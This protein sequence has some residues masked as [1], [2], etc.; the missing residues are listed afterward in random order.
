MSEQ[1][2]YITNEEGERVGVLL[3]IDEYNRLQN[4]TASDPEILVGID[5]SELQALAD[6]MLV[7][8][9]QRRLD[10]LLALNTENQL[11]AEESAEL[12]RLLTQVDHLTVLKTRARY[13][14]QSRIP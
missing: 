9:A 6:S 11:S 2:R 3:E 1:L 5:R 14:L 12:D 4:Q 10:E 13:T 8:S 7:P